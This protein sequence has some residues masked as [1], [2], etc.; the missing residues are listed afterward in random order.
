MRPPA[1]LARLALVVLGI[2]G[3]T[4]SAK[5][6][7]IEP[8]EVPA[9]LRAWVPWVVAG[10]PTYGCTRAGAEHVC[11]WPG[12]LELRVRQTEVAFALSVLL[13][14]E[15]AVAL[16]GGAGQWP[17]DVV[18]DGRAL[19]VVGA[20]DGA[21]AVTLEAGHHRVEGRFRFGRPPE[22]LRVPGASARV[23]S[24]D[25]A[26]AR[27]ALE[28]AGEGV[29]ALSTATSVGGADEEAAADRVSF[30]VVRRVED[31]VPLRIVTQILARV[32]G[33]PRA[34]TIEHA[35]VPGSVPSAVESEL[36][37]KVSA[38]G[39]VV[40]QARSG[41]HRMRV[42][43]LVLDPSA[44]LTAPAVPAPWPEREI[45]VFAP[46]E[47]HR[48]V[49]VKDGSSVD[50]QS[51]SIPEDW[52]SSAAFAVGGGEPF[53]LLEVRRGEPEP[54]RDALSFARSLWLDFDGQGFTVR[55]R[56]TGEMHRSHRL[57]LLEGDLG[58]VTLGGEDQLVTMPP[59]EARSAEGARGVEIRGARLDMVAEL[60]LDAS[61]SDLPAVGWSEEARSLSMELN[62]PPGHSLFAAVGVDEAPAAWLSKWDVGPLFLVL[63][64]TTIMLRLHGKLA[65]AVTLVTMA[66]VYHEPGAPRF[67]WLFVLLPAAVLGLARRGTFARLT[68]VAF[69]L[70][71]VM[72]VLSVGV[73]AAA[74]LRYALHPQLYTEDQLTTAVF[75]GDVVIEES[76]ASSA[77]S[78]AGYARRA[79]SLGDAEDADDASESNLRAPD[80]WIDPNA[81]VQTGYGVVDWRHSVAELRW[82]GPVAPD[83]RVHL[84]IVRPWMQRVL[85]Y[86]RAAGLLFLLFVL[87]RRRPT[88]PPAA[89]DAKEDEA[90]PPPSNRPPQAGLGV[91]VLFAFLAAASSASAQEAAPALPSETPSPLL[92]E[93]LRLRL[94]APPACGARCA[95]I[96]EASLSVDGDTL[97]LTM[98]A[99]AEALAALP[100]PGPAA[101]LVP[102]EV[103]VDGEPTDALRARADGHLELRLTPGV[104][105]VTLVAKLT[106]RASIA[107]SFPELPGRLAV[108]AVGWAVSGVDENGLVRG[109]IELRRQIATD[110]APAEG[111][112]GVA[113]VPVW[114]MVERHVDVGVQWIVETKVR[115]LS[116]T[117][118]PAV[119]RIPALP[120]EAVLGAEASLEGGFVVAT[121]GQ[122]VPELVFTSS[123]PPR[124][125]LALRFDVAPRDVHRSERWSFACSPLWHC[126]HEGI[127][128]IEHE[129]GGTFRPTFVP[130][131]GESIVLHARRLEA[132]PGPSV[133]IDAVSMKVTPGDRA[134]SSELDL[135]VRTSVSNTLKIGLP[136][137]VDVERVEV[138]GERRAVQRDGDVLRV[139]ITPSVY[140]V[141]VSFT[142]P[143]GMGL[144][145]ETPRIE[146]DSSMVDIDLEVITPSDRWLLFATGPEWG[147]IVLFWGYL[148]LALVIAV[149]LGRFPRSPL[150]AY[151]W[152]LLAVG[153]LQLPL[154]FTFLVA[155]WFFAVRF[156]HERSGALAPP[157]VTGAQATYF[158]FAQL[159]L[160]AYAC[161]SAVVLITA[162]WVGLTDRPDM[163]VVGH[164]SSANV[165][166][167]YQDRARGALPT[168]AVFSVSLWVWK[169]LMLAWAFWLARAV[170]RWTLWAVG[171][172]RERGFFIKGPPPPKSAVLPQR[173]QPKGPSPAP[174]GPFGIPVAP[175]PS[176][177]PGPREG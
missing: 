2:V 64:L 26:G 87:F 48:Q 65:A 33:R 113:D 11:A 34:L 20:A 131:P 91:A 4:S 129:E 161:L 30:E 123:I 156:Q 108:G 89:S 140:R 76:V 150:R 83:H 120:G 100:L 81:V 25:E 49:E 80:N 164:E 162:V 177:E 122:G 175:P 40:I 149:A 174:A 172:F 60:R 57:D 77:G 15:R 144:R 137:G 132:A 171:P 22:S 44:P 86:A 139:G 54:P 118:A 18:A 82:N 93:Q 97:R 36:P 31:G 95:Q 70:G 158:N 112:R 23:F 157:P 104:H 68:F 9:P 168:A 146:L 41:T 90:P 92:L 143:R 88:W 163:R 32:S 53:T 45:W 42:A 21:P 134:T 46:S 116:S 28:R 173:G 78:A 138:D 107:L 135:R 8:A 133:T 152:A 167:F 96:G 5:A 119:V 117:G 50:P 141:L 160:V 147:P 16:P 99:H 105:T 128:P 84:Y 39:N 13:D 101:S 98:V 14:R 74:Q 111:A 47:L 17:V 24:V 103:L 127:A 43:A 106:G 72:L 67:E 51:P 136:E 154:P 63:L 151:E 126:V 115:R 19:P 130:Y 52:R 27:T 125:E 159:V 59:G 121:L 58:R 166:S 109:T 7:P 124:S 75:Y 69:A 35:L 1:S 38:D 61:P 153:L 12:T 79:A 170:V 94:L 73:F 169:G 29:V 165:L 110:D 114:V 3:T 148:V 10:D 62:L 55:D 6:Q 37:I 85:A 145:F 176:E 71:G 155:G 142:E 102:D 66:L 56:I